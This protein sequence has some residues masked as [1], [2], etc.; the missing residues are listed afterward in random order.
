MSHAMKKARSCFEV[1]FAFA[2]S[3]LS[4]FSHKLPK[5]QRSITDRTLPA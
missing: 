5:M 2:E 1:T 3:V 4:K